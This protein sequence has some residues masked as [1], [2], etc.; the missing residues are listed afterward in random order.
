M[1]LPDTIAVH[2][3]VSPRTTSFAS[4]ERWHTDPKMDP[5]TRLWRYMGTSGLKTSQLPIEIRQRHG[6]GNGWP[7]PGYNV[8]INHRG[9]RK[10]WRE[11]PQRGSAV[12]RANTGKIS[13]LLMGDNTREGRRWNQDQVDSLRELL[14][15]YTITWPNL[16]GH[17]FGHRDVSKRGH[18]TQCP[19]LDIALLMAL[20]WSVERYWNDRD[21][22]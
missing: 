13:I 21:M 17:I 3:S 4:V 19:G 2:H 22:P 12:A 8:G 5:K 7:A 20:D 16:R 15:A 1:F 11:V 10:I 9:E 18:S 6:R 14:N